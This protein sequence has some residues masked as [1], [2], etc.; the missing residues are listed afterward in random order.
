MKRW[1]AGW[2][3]HSIYG[4]HDKACEKGI[5]IELFFSLR[6]LALEAMMSVCETSG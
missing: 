2:L 5:T 1:D 3:S 6:I 4:V